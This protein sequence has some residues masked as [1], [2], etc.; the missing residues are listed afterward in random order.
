[1]SDTA[2]PFSQMF[3]VT[4]LANT[5]KHVK[6]ELDERARADLA[7]TYDLA[8][9]ESFSAELEVRPFRRKGA[10]VRGSLSAQVTQKCSV[11]L[12]PV[13]E[14]VN[15]TFERTFIPEEAERPRRQKVDEELELLVDVEEK[16]PPEG[17][18]GGSIDLGAVLCEH[19]ALA[20]NPFPR[21]DGVLMDEKYAP[22]PE[23]EAQIEEEKR[24]NSPF[25]ALKALK[26]NS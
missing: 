2:Y 16:D 10:A 4:R 14:T 6:I 18:A 7:N 12:E 9:V 24:Q 15:D 20:L 19:F 11:T 8:E 21:A 3:D 17:F 5:P 26:D 13:R 1:M 22:Q 23:D 25:A